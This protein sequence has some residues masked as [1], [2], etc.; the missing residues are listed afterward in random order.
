MINS[1]LAIVL[2]WGGVASVIAALLL[3]PPPWSFIVC[4]LGGLA[5]GLGLARITE[6]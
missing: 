3:M 5:A 1:Q 4:A 6:D 2:F